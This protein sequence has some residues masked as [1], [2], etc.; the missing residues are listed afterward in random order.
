MRDNGRFAEIEV[1]V[2]HPAH[3]DLL[4]RYRKVAAEAHQ[5]EQLVRVVAAKGPRAIQ[6]ASE[7][8]V[9]AVRRRKVLETQLEQLGITER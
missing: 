2:N 1:P 6:L 9:K 7:T 4:A 8:A 5:K 3:A